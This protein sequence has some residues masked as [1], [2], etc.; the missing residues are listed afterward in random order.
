VVCGELACQRKRRTE[1]HRQKIAADPE[2][3]DVCRDS[4]R[5][6]ESAIRITGRV[7]AGNIPKRLTGI[8]SSRSSVIGNGQFAMHKLRMSA[9]HD[10]IPALA[11]SYRELLSFKLPESRP[12]S[13]WNR[14]GDG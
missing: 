6:G 10:S 12:Q 1:Y 11:A 14:S 8:A 13:F 3:R 2:Y 7:T 4:P 5:N 9:R